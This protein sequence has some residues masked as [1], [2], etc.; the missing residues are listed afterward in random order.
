[1]KI[2]TN[3]PG[4]WHHAPPHLFMPGAIYMITA[5]TRD[6]ARLFNSSEKLNQ[7]REVIFGQVSRYG[8]MLEAWALFENHYHLVTR[9][10]EK[11]DSL[12]QMMRTIHS[13]SALWLN[14]LD[15]APGRQVWFQYRDTCLT[16]EKSYLARLHYVHNNPVKH[17]IVAAAEQYP[18]CSMAWFL[19]RAQDGF[20]KTVLS[21]KIDRLAVDDDF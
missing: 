7:L 9:A 11:V 1:M 12:K 15:N 13:Q 5:S 20:R 3:D 18:W 14:Q 10:P 17:G 16:Y 19:N 6:K 2:V 21:F 8:W 4:A